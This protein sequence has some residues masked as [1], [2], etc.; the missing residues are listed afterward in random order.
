FKDMDILGSWAY[1][2]TQFATCLD[3]MKLSVD[4]LPLREIVTHRFKVGDA[5]KAMDN[6]L[7]RRGIKSAIKS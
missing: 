1:P 3:L 7:A 6:V 4:R 5:Q 2:P